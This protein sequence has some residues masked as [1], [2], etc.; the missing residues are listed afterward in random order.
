MQM[1]MYMKVNG[2]MTKLMDMEYINIQMVLNLKEIG[3]RTNKMV[4]A[5]KLG[6]MVQ[7]MKG[8]INKDKKME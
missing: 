2:V 7:D 1:V 8:T 3:I 5:L 4:K 6:L